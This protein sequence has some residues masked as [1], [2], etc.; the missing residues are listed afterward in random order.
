MRF[1]IIRYNNVCK[2]EVTLFQEIRIPQKRLSLRKKVLHSAEIAVVGLLTGIIIKMLDLYT[3]NLGNIFSQLS[4]WILL[5][6]VIAVYSSTSKRAA[7]NVFLFC[8]GMLITYYLTAELT[9]SPYSLVFVYGWAVF[10]LCSPLFAFFTWYA[11]GK[12]IISKLLTIG[13]IVVMLI[14]A[15]VLFDKIRISDIIIAI[16]TAVVLLT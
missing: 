15:V 2:E 3:T 8:V 13:I 11:K 4:V 6:S 16:L 5:C 12:S 9:G 1:R 7:V 10:S 14:A